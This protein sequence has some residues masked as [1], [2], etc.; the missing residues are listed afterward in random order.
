MALCADDDLG[1]PAT[2]EKAVRILPTAH[3]ARIAFNLAA[4]APYHLARDPAK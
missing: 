2:H 3:A 1:L 4:F